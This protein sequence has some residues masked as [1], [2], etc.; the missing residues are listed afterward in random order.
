MRSTAFRHSTNKKKEENTQ[1]NS[2]NNYVTKKP[3]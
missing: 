1:L 3:S 2:N